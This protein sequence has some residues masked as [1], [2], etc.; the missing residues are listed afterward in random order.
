MAGGMNR[1]R[2]I[3]IVKVNVF[4]LH[5]MLFH[6]FTLPVIFSLIGGVAEPRETG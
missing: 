1:M 5:N 3:L 4:L 6:L 2:A